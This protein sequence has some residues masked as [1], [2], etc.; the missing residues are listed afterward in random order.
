MHWIRWGHKPG[1]NRECWGRVLRTQIQFWDL[2]SGRDKDQKFKSKGWS[3]KKFQQV[4]DTVHQ[5]N[6]A[7]LQSYRKAG[8]KQHKRGWKKEDPAAGT[9]TDEAIVQINWKDGEVFNYILEKG[10]VKYRDMRKEG[11]NPK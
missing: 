2:S 1:Y 6:Y 5:E 10:A 11:L 8:W 3:W 7:D 4:N 9:R